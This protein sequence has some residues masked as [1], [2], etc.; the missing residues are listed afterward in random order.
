MR[1][2]CLGIF[3]YDPRNLAFFPVKSE[4]DLHINFSSFSSF[5]EM[6]VVREVVC[7]HPTQIKLTWGLR[8]KFSFP[9][10]LICALKLCET[11]TISV[12][13]IV[14]SPPLLSWNKLLLVR[15]RATKKGEWDGWRS[16]M[17]CNWNQ[18]PTFFLPSPSFY[19]GK[20]SLLLSRF[21]LSF[22]FLSIS[23]DFTLNWLLWTSLPPFP[24]QSFLNEKGMRVMVSLHEKVAF[25]ILSKRERETNEKIT[26]MLF[27]S[28]PKC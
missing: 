8:K 17:Q 10:E 7:E 4:Y 5:Q 24:I 13:V 20:I 6:H 1:S 3:L 16:N 21:L 19:L 12:A 28:Y 27:N 25:V 15:E 23:S 18:W 11:W 14:D 26:I 2:P 9:F 22:V